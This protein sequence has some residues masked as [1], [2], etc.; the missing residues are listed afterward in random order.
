MTLARK[1]TPKNDIQGFGP[2]LS[3]VMVNEQKEDRDVVC[4][5]FNYCSQKIK[6]RNLLHIALLSVLKKHQFKTLKY[7]TASIGE[8][9][10]CM[11]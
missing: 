10:A 7:E 2:K 6:L 11:L 4:E 9:C 3:V 5:S 8:Q 1:L